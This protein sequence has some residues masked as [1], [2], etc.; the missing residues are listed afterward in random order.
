MKLVD[1]NAAGPKHLPPSSRGLIFRE[2]AQLA[3]SRMNTPQGPARADGGLRSRNQVTEALAKRVEYFPSLVGRG[4]ETPG[5]I[6]IRSSDRQ[7]SGLDQFLCQ[8]AK[9]HLADPEHAD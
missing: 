1:S 6:V 3:Q 9:P 5:T 4:R 2:K 7:P 8:L